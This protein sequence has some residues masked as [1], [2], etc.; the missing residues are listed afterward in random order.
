M[1]ARRTEGEL[2]LGGTESP[3]PTNRPDLP[4]PGS[5]PLA[6]TFPALRQVLAVCAEDPLADKFNDIDD[7]RSQVPEVME[8]LTTWLRLYKTRD[9]LAD[10]QLV[11]FPGRENKFAFDGQPQGRDFAMRLVEET[12]ESWRKLL[13]ERAAGEGAGKPAIA[14]AGLT[15][16][17]SAAKL[18]GGL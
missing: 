11:A 18:V 14:A 8:A 1:P 4:T 2:L 17:L 16:N 15:R 5:P 7:V 12:H 10:G 3:A 6:R 9:M 13:S